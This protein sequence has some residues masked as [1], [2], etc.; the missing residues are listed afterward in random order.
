M[1]A[2]LPISAILR[3]DQT[4][5][6]MVTGVPRAT[7]RA[8]RIRY[9]FPAPPAQAG[10]S[11]SPA[12]S[13]A[14]LAALKTFAVMFEKGIAH[15][16]ARSAAFAVRDRVVDSQTKGRPMPE[17]MVV[18]SGRDARGRPSNPS[19]EFCSSRELG[20]VALAMMT[21]YA[22]ASVMDLHLVVKAI[23]RGFETWHPKFE[24]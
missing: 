1:T 8:W 7:L 21:N 12:L 2:K 10:D 22:A 16:A 4:V 9:H 24:T 23:Q 5:A 3:Y 13:M 11:R 18:G 20:A 6:A 14:D 19:V 15:D 17:M